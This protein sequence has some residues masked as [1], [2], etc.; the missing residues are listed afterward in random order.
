MRTM[1]I[2]AALACA[3]LPVAAQDRSYTPGTVWTFNHIDIAEGQSENYMD[4]LA[5]DW[6]ADQEFR[7]R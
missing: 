6:K 7:K 5:K 1:L 4:Y 3:A 2:A